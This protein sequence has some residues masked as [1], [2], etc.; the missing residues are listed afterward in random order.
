MVLLFLRVLQPLL[1][2]LDVI[3]ILDDANF[4]HFYGIPIW[5]Y[6]KIPLFISNY[7]TIDNNKPLQQAAYKGLLRYIVILVWC[8]HASTIKL[9]LLINNM[10]RLVIDNF[11]NTRT[12]LCS[13]G[14]RFADVMAKRT[15]LGE[16]PLTPKLL[17]ELQHEILVD[18]NVIEQYGVR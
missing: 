18:K 17:A 6:W 1:P 11:N 2:S 15:G 7:R 16:L 13:F 9:K 10:S 4:W 12:L 3:D 5:R 8:A 14:E